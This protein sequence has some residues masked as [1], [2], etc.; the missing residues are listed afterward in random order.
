MPQID[1]TPK[2][3]DVGRELIVEM[4]KA[5]ATLSSNVDKLNQRVEDL[6]AS[7]DDHRSI[8]ED[9]NEN[10]AEISGLCSTFLQVVDDLSSVAADD[11]K[12]VEWS[13]VNVILKKMKESAEEDNDD[14]DDDE[15]GEEVKSGK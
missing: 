15:G 1:S 5:M 10:M 12:E 6:V 7:L 14:D 2:K 9:L 13:D 11:D 3:G 4:V 8:S